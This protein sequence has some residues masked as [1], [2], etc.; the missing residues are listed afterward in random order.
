MGKLVPFCCTVS[1]ACFTLTD[2]LKLHLMIYNYCIHKTILSGD[3]L[4]VKVAVYITKGRSYN[5]RVSVG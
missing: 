4:S 5:V 3:G 1:A 2:L